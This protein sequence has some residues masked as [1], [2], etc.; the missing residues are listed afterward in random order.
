MVTKSEVEK[1][2]REVREWSAKRKRR[3]EA[4]QNLE[5]VLLQGEWGREELWERAGVEE[6]CYVAG[7]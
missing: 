5:A 3:V 2:D 6:D 1:V 4:F 7:S